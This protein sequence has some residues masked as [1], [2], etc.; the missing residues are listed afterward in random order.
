MLVEKAACTWK[1]NHVGLVDVADCHLCTNR[2]SDRNLRMMRWGGGGSGGIMP[3][4]SRVGRVAYAAG[5]EKKKPLPPSCE[6]EK[7]RKFSYVRMK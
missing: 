4:N 7:E 6:S 1:I 2:F 5:G 3:R